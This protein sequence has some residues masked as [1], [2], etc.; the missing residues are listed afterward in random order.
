MDRME[1]YLAYAAAFILAGIVTIFSSP[2]AI[3]LAFHFG[4]LDKPDQRKVHSKA[5]PR[6]GGL[7]I[8]SG[9][10]ITILILSLVSQTIRDLIIPHHKP[11]V[12]LASGA[13]LMFILG[14]VDDIRGLSPRT[15]LEFQILAGMLAFYGGFQ[16]LLVRGAASGIRSSEVWT[17][18]GI[19]LT[20]FWT[21]G[22]TNAVN[23]IDGLDGLAAGITGIALTCLGLISI[24]NHHLS[25]A[26]AAFTIAGASFGFLWHNRHPAKIFLGDSGSLLLGFLLAALSIEGTQQGSLFASLVGPLCLLYIPILDTVLAMVRRSQKGVPFSFAD[27]HHIHH[28]LLRNGIHHPHVVLI[29]WAVTLGVGCIGLSIHFIENSYRSLVVNSFAL[30]VLALTIRYLGNL[31]LVD[32]LRFASKINRRKKTPRGKIVSLRRRLREVEK[33]ETAESLLRNVALIAESMELDSLAVS[34]SPRSSA[35]EQVSIYR[36]EYSKA[37]KAESKDWIEKPNLLANVQAST[38][39]RVQM[40]SYITVELGRQNWK[41]RRHSEDVQ[42]WANLIVEKLAEMKALRI[43]CPGESPMTLSLS[44][45]Q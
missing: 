36:W 20:V 30:F 24:L 17:I 22:T 13:T 45:I 39:Y 41:L 6:M 23:L 40:E 29:L 35:E 21:V 32:Y 12:F 18:L 26:L 5:I 43:F 8:F 34:M 7:A 33:C 15:K 1:I 38:L 19:I 31:E 44:Q 37:K 25:T 10:L 42:L 27:N 4:I 9:I 28:R 11:F 16:F 14:L 2:I 3:R